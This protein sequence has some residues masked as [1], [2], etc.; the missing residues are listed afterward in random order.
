VWDADSG[1]KV[2]T[3]VTPGSTQFTEI[4]WS[5]D[6]KRIAAAADDGVLRFWNA[7]DGRL[8]SSLLMLSSGNEWLLV[9]AD[10]RIDGTEQARRRLVSWRADGA[11]R[12]D[13]TLTSR[14]RVPGLWRELARE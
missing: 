8:M 7:A 11:V 4:A 10:G 2:V 13:A 5:P 6:G 1:Q 14:V 9:A 12:F 3:L